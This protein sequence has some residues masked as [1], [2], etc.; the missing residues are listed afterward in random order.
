M[1]QGVKQSVHL[2]KPWRRATAWWALLIEGIVG[3]G[4]GVALL[5]WP[6]S[7]GLDTALSGDCAWRRRG[8]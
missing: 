3:A 8:C 7:A 2:I 4:L 5:L 6:A 1:K